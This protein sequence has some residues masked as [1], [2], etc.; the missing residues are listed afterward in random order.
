MATGRKWELIRKIRIAEVKLGLTGPSI[1]GPL[2]QVK[3]EDLLAIWKRL[4]R[5]LEEKGLIKQRDAA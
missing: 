3:V 4:H 1:E 2:S 5:A